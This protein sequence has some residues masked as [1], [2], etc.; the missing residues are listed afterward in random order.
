MRSKSDAFN[1]AARSGLCRIYSVDS[2]QFGK[3]SLEHRPK[4]FKRYGFYD[5]LLV[6]RTM[7][8]DNHYCRSFC[9][10][11]ANRP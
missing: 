10:G 1:K 6:V 5:A 9:F 11:L 7:Q 3:Q 2:T 8:V 4:I